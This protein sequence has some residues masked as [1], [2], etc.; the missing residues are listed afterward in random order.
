MRLNPDLG[1]AQEEKSPPPN[2]PQGLSV[3][4]R[5]PRL[6]LGGAALRNA[7]ARGGR[8]VRLQ[9]CSPPQ[10]RPALASVCVRVAGEPNHARRPSSAA[11]ADG[12]PQ[13][14]AAGSLSNEAL[15]SAV[16]EDEG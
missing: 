4:A 6:T 8:S 13:D 3:L 14:E 5:T 11:R 7:N 1:D 9:Q 2:A 16:A 15:V 10:R 12:S